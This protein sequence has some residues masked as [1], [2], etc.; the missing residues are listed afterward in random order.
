MSVFHSSSIIVFS[1]TA[2]GSDTSCILLFS[3]VSVFGVLQDSVDE[4]SLRSL[5]TTVLRDAING[6]VLNEFLVNRNG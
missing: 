2:C 6:D 4:A 1:W 5:T 3:D